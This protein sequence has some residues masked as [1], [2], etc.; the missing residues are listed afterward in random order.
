[1]LSQ[2]A[3]IAD[4]IAAFAIVVSLLF[5]AYELR[6]TRKQ[7]ELTNWREVLQTLTDYK[8]QTNDPALS[9]IIV[10]GHADYH[11][12]SA[13]EQ[14]TFGLYLEQGV[15]IIG[16]FLKHNDSLPEKLVGLEGAIGNHF[17]EM[18][19][20]SGG[21]EW[22][23]QSQENHRFMPDT[24]RITNDLLERRKA[25]GGAPLNSKKT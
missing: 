22:W 14:L 20:T 4:L 16:N 12:L 17:H 18:L 2:I 5:V 13:A 3:D 23:R 6:E 9:E 10:R 24:Y 25:N 7:T 1:M 21:A 8:S 15:H 19:T 11:A